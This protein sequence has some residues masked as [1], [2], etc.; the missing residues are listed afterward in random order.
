MYYKETLPIKICNINNL[1][2]CLLC[3]ISFNN[4]KCFIKSLYR[5]PSQSSDEFNIFLKELE[6]IIDNI[7]T[8]GNSDL[9]II[10]G[11]FNAKLSIW[12]LDDSDSTE[13]TEISAMTSSYGFT[14]IISEATP[15]LPTS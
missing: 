2:E 1:S 13:G 3:E 4:Q 5:A 7:C 15:I 6:V 8:P 12:N 11:D 14:Q 9:V 10:I